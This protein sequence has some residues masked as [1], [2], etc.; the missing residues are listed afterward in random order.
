MIKMWLMDL[1]RHFSKADIR[2]NKHIKDV[3][4]H[5]PLEKC[6]AKPW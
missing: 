5:Y 1:N 2:K 6:K 3:Q 4:H